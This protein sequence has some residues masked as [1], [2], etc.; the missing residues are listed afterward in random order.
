MMGGARLE[1]E[2]E[3]DMAEAAEGEGW[4]EEPATGVSVATTAGG[5]SDCLVKRAC[6]GPGEDL[7][8]YSDDI[9]GGKSSVERVTESSSSSSLSLVTDEVRFLQVPDQPLRTE[10]AQS[11]KVVDLDETADDAPVLLTE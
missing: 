4:R 2:G 9:G 6:V 3:G 7:A 11:V 1:E 5:L 8:E 10:P